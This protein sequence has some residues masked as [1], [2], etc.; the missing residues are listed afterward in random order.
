MMRGK[1]VLLIGGCNKIG[2]SVARRLA[3]EGASLVLP[4]VDLA[5]LHDL[6][7]DIQKLGG[8][9]TLVQADVLDVSQIAPLKEVIS[10]TFKRL[11]VLI[12]AHFY[13]SG[14]NLL[15]DYEVDEWK[16]IIE[17]N[18]SLNWYMLK[19]FDGLLK[20]SPHGR[21]VFL[22]LEEIVGKNPLYFSPYVASGV[23]LARLMEGY[24]NDVLNYGMRVNMVGLEGYEEGISVEPQPECL[25]LFLRL[26]SER[27]KISGRKH[28]VSYT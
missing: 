19:S 28:Y 11:D 13:T 15:V 20:R 4:G 1:V 6:S 2:A 7:Q 25:E 21:V 10:A 22:F 18:F 17:E 23:A 27:Y 5:N 9:V 24:A 14:P 3:A 8:E 16:K 12:S 26:T